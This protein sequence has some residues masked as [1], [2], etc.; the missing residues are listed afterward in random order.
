MALARTDKSDAPF[1]FM[2]FSAPLLLPNGRVCQSRIYKYNEIP[3][4]ANE[5]SRRQAANILQANLTTHV[6]NAQVLRLI[7][8]REARKAIAL[9]A[10]MM[11]VNKT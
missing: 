5:T 3:E 9:V 4:E 1:F 8:E 6:H 10:Q 7:A 11:T 2:V